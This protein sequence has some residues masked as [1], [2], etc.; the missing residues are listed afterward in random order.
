LIDELLR[1]WTCIRTLGSSERALGKLQETAVSTRAVAA[2]GKM[3]NAV[4]TSNNQAIGYLQDIFLLVIGTYFMIH[5][6][7]PVPIFM[8]FYVAAGKLDDQMPKVAACLA[9]LNQVSH[10][11]RPS[12]GH[13]TT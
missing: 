6:G 8:A 10:N 2:T 3:Q 1:N 12:V 7:M 11:T 4:G 13:R 5:A 9:I